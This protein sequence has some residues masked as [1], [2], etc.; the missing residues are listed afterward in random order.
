MLEPLISSSKPAPVSAKRT[1][2]RNFMCHAASTSNMALTTI[3]HNKFYTFRSPATTTLISGL[4][5]FRSGV[6]A[7]SKT[8]GR[9]ST[10]YLRLNVCFLLDIEMPPFS[11]LSVPRIKY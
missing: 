8:G 6:S 11:L 5:H 1:P 2:V 7:L 9:F 4:I 3:C 10:R